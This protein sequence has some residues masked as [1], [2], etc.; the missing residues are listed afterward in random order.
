MSDK[1]T[2]TINVTAINDAPLNTVP[3]PQTVNED[4]ALVFSSA[5]GNA[6]SINDVDAASGSEQVTLTVTNGNLSLAS[7]AGLT[8]TTGSGT[9][10]PTMVFTGTIANINTALNGLT[11]NPTGN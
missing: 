8:F 5:N 4:T 1:D 3:A 7:T 10:N 2:V 6:I 11:F 9:N